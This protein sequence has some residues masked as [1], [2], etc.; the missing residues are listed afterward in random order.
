M[1]IK[2]NKRKPSNGDIRRVYRFAWFPKRVN[3]YIIW[4]EDYSE[5]QR[6]D[7]GEYNWAGAVRNKGWIVI[8]QE[9]ES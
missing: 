6:Y 5:R 2:L 7:E 1:K 3:D 9:I 8:E 4:L